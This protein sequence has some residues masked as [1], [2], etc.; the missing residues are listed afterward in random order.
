[1]VDTIT[2]KA[3]LICMETNRHFWLKSTF[4]LSRLGLKST[5]I[6][7]HSEI[8]LQ[9]THGLQI[10]STRLATNEST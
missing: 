10:N 7:F 3:E 1:M 4:G 8:Q 9:S 2:N 5:Q 6:H